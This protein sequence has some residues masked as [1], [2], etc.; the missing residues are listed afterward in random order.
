[1]GFRGLIQGGQTAGQAKVQVCR[2]VVQGR[3]AAV[4]GGRL[5]VG[6]SRLAGD[7][8]RHDFLPGCRL[9]GSQIRRR[10]RGKR[11]GVLEVA[12]RG[13][14]HTQPGSKLAWRPTGTPDAQSPVNC[15]NLAKMGVDCGQA[16]VVG[17]HLATRQTWA[18]PARRQR[19]RFGVAGASHQA[20]KELARPRRLDLD[21]GADER[22]ARC[23]R[24]QHAG[25]P[26]G[27]HHLVVA[28]VDDEQVRLVADTL[29]RD[30]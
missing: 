29:A 26:I 23:K 15:R 25:C 17:C 9:L 12:G 7:S 6:A 14:N 4:T 28:H 11:S 22:Q 20:G 27:P 30:G 8:L 18:C 24:A 2:L 5:G 1:M 10:H 16:R 3:G 13:T 19:R 21:T